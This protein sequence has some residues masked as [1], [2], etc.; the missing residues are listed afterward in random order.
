MLR[1]GHTTTD[2]KCFQSITQSRGLRCDQ[3]SCHIVLILKL[4]EQTVAME[5]QKGR[6]AGKQWDMGKCYRRLEHDPG[7]EVPSWYPW[8]ERLPNILP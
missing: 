2:N 1:L 7:K 6:K 3:I 5:S 4:E 8:R